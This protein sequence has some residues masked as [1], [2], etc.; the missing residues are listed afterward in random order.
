M[1]TA[2]PPVTILPGHPAWSTASLAYGLRRPPREWKIPG[3]NPTRAGIFPGT[4]HTSDLKVGT[5]VAILP[6]GW[7]YRVS[8]QTGQPGVSKLW[9]GETE[10]LVFNFYLSMAARKLSEQICSWDTLA[11]CWDT[12]QL[13][14][15]QHDQCSQRIIY[16]LKRRSTIYCLK[17]PR[18][19]ENKTFLSTA[20]FLTGKMSLDRTDGKKFGWKSNIQT[21][22]DSPPLPGKTHAV[23]VQAAPPSLK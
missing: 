12:K 7:R 2:V 11:C 10:N 8:A 23:L 17:S 22:R 14:N 1:V 20:N 18:A 3:S 6:G 9:L 4:S 13:T 5:P 15:K 21:H 16:C 19:S